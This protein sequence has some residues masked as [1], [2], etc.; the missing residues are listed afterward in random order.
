MLMF[1]LQGGQCWFG[2]PQRS[3]QK[4][5]SKYLLILVR[6]LLQVVTFVAD[7][8][9]EVGKVAQELLCG[10]RG[11]KHPNGKFP[12]IHRENF[13]GGIHFKHRLISDISYNNFYARHI[14][15]FC[16]RQ[17]EKI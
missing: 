10:R 5:M 13:V 8:W 1:P 2:K 9:L 16:K 15:G 17:K 11:Q 7:L 14:L 6:K 4:K 3:Y 12:F